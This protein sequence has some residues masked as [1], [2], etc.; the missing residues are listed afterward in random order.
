MRLPIFETVLGGLTITGSIVGT[1]HDLEEVFALH[2]RGKTEI[3]RSECALDDVNDAIE[4]VLDGSAGTARTV[5]RMSATA[6][7]INSNGRPMLTKV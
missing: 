1:H 3:E 6:T 7:S 2:A 4:A 5:L